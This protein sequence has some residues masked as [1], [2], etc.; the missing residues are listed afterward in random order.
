[1][2]INYV[3]GDLFRTPIKHIMHGCNAQ[4]RMGSGVALIVRNIHPDAYKAYLEWNE[5]ALGNVQFVPSN[6]KVI[7][8]A[9][10]QQFYGKDGKKYVSYDAIETVMKKVNFMLMTQ[11]HEEVAMPKIGATL[12]GGN[13]NIIEKIIE[14]NMK[15]VQ[16][17]VYYL[18]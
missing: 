9:V 16:P 2:K 12:G 4:R 1:M 5:L 17:V 18:E 3:Q 6:E 7:I 11:G 8:N 14:E 15:E 13:W 10:T